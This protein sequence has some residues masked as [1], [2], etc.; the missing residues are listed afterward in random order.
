MAWTI[1]TPGV[2]PPSVIP[3]QDHSSLLISTGDKFNAFIGFY[4]FTEP[5]QQLTVGHFMPRML[6][7]IIG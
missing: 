1:R 6:T 3:G 2:S 5:L 4:L 7:E